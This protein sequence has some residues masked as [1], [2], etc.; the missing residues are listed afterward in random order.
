MNPQGILDN[1]NRKGRDLSLKNE[2]TQELIQ[3]RADAERNFQVALAQTITK[4]KIDGTPITVIKDLA[5]GDKVVANLK[6]ELD[7]AEGILRAC[8]KSM[9]VITTQ[10]DVL[11]SQ[12][13]WLKGEMNRT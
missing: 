8:Y 3:K 4:L 12:L 1:L 6:Y 11:R 7:I 13:S 2:E 5:K 10:I 9:D